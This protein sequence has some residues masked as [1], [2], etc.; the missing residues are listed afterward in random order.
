[1]LL[2]CISLSQVER[3][4]RPVSG[5]SRFSLVLSRALLSLNDGDER[6]LDSSSHRAFKARRLQGGKTGSFFPTY[7]SFGGEKNTNEERE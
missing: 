6:P 2:K 4:R 7:G 1:M 5:F 3:G